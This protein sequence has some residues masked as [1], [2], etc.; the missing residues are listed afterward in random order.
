MG[1]RPGLSAIFS[2]PGA[3]PWLL[4][5]FFKNGVHMFMFMPMLARQRTYRGSVLSGCLLPSYPGGRLSS[6][7]DFPFRPD[8]PSPC[9]A[10]RPNSGSKVIQKAQRVPHG[11]AAGRTTRT[12]NSR[13]RGRLESR[14]RLPLEIP[15]ASVEEMKDVCASFPSKSHDMT[16]PTDTPVSGSPANP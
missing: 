10:L 11:T 2:R 9:Q 8:L 5:F 4:P 13:R 6:G 7:R 12:H 1:S 3:V 16:Y 14:R 15:N